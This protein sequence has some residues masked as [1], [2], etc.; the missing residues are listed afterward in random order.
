MVCAGKTIL[1]YADQW[2][3]AYLTNC[4][5]Q[6]KHYAFAYP[7]GMLGGSIVL[8][9]AK[10]KSADRLVGRSETGRLETYSFTLSL[11]LGATCDVSCCQWS[12]TTQL[13]GVCDLTRPFRRRIP[14]DVQQARKTLPKRLLDNETAASSAGPGLVV[15]ASRASSS[16]Q[17][18]GQRCAAACGTGRRDG[19]RSLMPQGPELEACA[20]GYGVAS[21]GAA[22]AT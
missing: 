19:R 1:P 17:W 20:A 15:R 5:T 9:P 7:M 4:E 8:A 18:I 22:L 3:Q 12:A 11:M 6:A 16:A 21:L 10:T 2:S 13:A 14:Q